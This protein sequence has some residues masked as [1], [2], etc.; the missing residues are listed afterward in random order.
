VAASWLVVLR[1]VLMLAIA[2]AGGIVLRQTWRVRVAA[3][4][5]APA[6]AAL[7]HD[8]AAAGPPA[9]LWQ[10]PR[11]AF[12][13]TD[14]RIVGAA[15]LRG[16]VW[17][18]DFIFTRC[19]TMCPIITAKMSVLR[20]AIA[21]RD[22][23]FVSFS[24][25]PEYDTPAV[26]AA[27]ART[28]SADPR[29][30]LLSPPP[31][32]VIQ[33]AS[34][35]NVPFERTSMPDEP[36]LHTTLFFLVDREGWVRGIYGS[37]DDAAVRRL[38]VDAAKLDA[39]DH[40]LATSALS[41]SAHQRSTET[42]VSRGRALFREL[43]CGACHDSPKLGPSLA[44]L[45]GRAV[46]LGGG[47][48]VVADD[49]YL[50]RSIVDPGDEVVAGYNALMPAYR[51]HLAAG[52]VDALVAHVNSLAAP[53]GG[54]A[55]ADVADVDVQDPVCGMQLKEARAAGQLGYHG[56]TYHFCSERCRIRFS[57]DPGR[58]LR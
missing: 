48:T 32:Q 5:S 56:K 8:L 11:F 36:I 19:V 29:W 53:V 28:W 51:D 15:D 58:Y 50:R 2:V 41:P 40:P 31:G 33:F 43:G 44:G 39:N 4:A 37:L 26:L 17:I 47:A 27:Y 49:A 34:A 54:A 38:A 6:S 1:L 16:H 55:P 25:E 3:S 42:A 13:G 52:D 45:A 22:V 12:A 24:V 57:K 20:R 7:T 35:M 46:K 18:A 30:L 23:R 9:R 21:S 14:G 10:V